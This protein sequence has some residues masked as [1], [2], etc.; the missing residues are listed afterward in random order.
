MSKPV[1]RRTTSRGG[2]LRSTT[3]KE[4]MQIQCSAAHIHFDGF[5]EGGKDWADVVITEAVTS[6]K[7]DRAPV[8]IGMNMTREFAELL[9]EFFANLAGL[10]KEEQKKRPENRLAQAEEARRC[11]EAQMESLHAELKAVRSHKRKPKA[12][13]P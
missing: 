4:G 10:M 11:A 3:F 5:V 8:A 6:L 7:P 2:V 1:V 12:L 9:A 13:T